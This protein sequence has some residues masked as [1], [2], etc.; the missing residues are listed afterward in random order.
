MVWY[1]SIR[2]TTRARMDEFRTPESEAIK[3]MKSHHFPNLID[4]IPPNIYFLR[5]LY[6]SY[7]PAQILF[8]IQRPKGSI[9]YATM[10]KGRSLIHP[11]MR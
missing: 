1:I 10:R 6:Y 11:C 9:E 3:Q 7:F 4:I 5:H 2:P 8:E